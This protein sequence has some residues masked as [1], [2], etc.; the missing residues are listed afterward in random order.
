MWYPA[1]A[2]MIFRDLQFCRK[3]GIANLTSSGLLQMW[4]VTQGIKLCHSRF[5]DQFLVNLNLFR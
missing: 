3:G 4:C 1:F 5:C 2:V